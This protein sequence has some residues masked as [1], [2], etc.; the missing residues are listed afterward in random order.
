MV[1]ADSKIGSCLANYLISKG[2]RVLLTTRRRETVSDSRIFLDLSNDV[3]NWRI[4]EDISVA[5]LCAAVTSIAKCRTMPLESYIVNVRNTLILAK[6]LIS[7][8]TFLVFPS[9]NLVYDCKRPFLKAEEPLNPR[10]EYGRQKAEVEKH[11]SKM[12]KGVSIVGVIRFYNVLRRVFQISGSEE[13]S[14]EQIARHIARRLSASQELVKPVLAR[15]AG[16]PPDEALEHSSLDTTRLKNELGL[17]PPNVW[18]TID[19]VVEI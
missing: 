3:E 14:Y 1:G 9:T 15:E 4:I 13:I 11:L 19:S 7:R 8:S 5:Y 18:H 2:E 6:N 17:V 12:G 16:V 10:T